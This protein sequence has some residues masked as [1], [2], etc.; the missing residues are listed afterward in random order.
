M[1]ASDPKRTIVPQQPFRLLP[2][3][4]TGVRHFCI[5][6]ILLIQGTTREHGSVILVA[7][8]SPSDVLDD[9]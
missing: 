1:A 8:S 6:L 7:L 9:Q 3:A 2:T 5:F 4:K